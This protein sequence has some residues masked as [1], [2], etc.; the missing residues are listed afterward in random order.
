M[1]V[2]KN[3]FLTLALLAGLQLQAQQS[4]LIRNVR[5][6]DPSQNKTSKPSYILIKGNKIAEIGTNREPEADSTIE[7][8]GRFVLPGLMDGHVHYFQSGGLYTRPDAIDLRAI[9]PYEEQIEWVRAQ[10]PDFFQRYLAAG[11]TYTCD[12]GGPM[13]N[14]MLREEA[15]AE[16]APQLFVTGPLIST[17]QPE[18]LAV[19]DAPIVKVNNAAEARALVQ[20]QLPFKPDFIKIWYIVLP[21]QN[22]QDHFEIVK[23]TIEESHA[24]NIPVAVHATQFETAKLAVEAGC[25]ILVHSVEDEK[26]DQA[27]AQGL[28]KNKVSY[29][30]TLEVGHNYMEVFSKHLNITAEDYALANPFTLGSLMDLAHLSEEEVPAWIKRVQTAEA[31]QDKDQAVMQHNLKL[32]MD[33]G[34]NVVTGTDAGNIGTLHASSYFAEL[35]AMQAAGLSNAQILQASTLNGAKMLGQAKTMGQLKAGFAADLILLDGNP[36]D[37]LAQL[38]AL[39]VVVRKGVA[40]DA[41]A[42]VPNSPEI[43]AQRQLNAYNQRN[44]EAFVDCYA[45]SV[46][47]YGYPD[48]LYYTGKDKMGPNYGPMFENTPELHCELVN[49][50]VLGNTVIDHENVTG[51]SNGRIIKAVAI[52]TVENGKIS[53]VRFVQ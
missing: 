53:V 24:N 20:K 18:E 35:Q 36:L 2:I 27:F 6:V 44:I 22:A 13:S 33:A 4:L 25:D 17:Y 30:P 49:R 21:G 48:Q 32:L 15:K 23:A 43:M 5:L 51:F 9:K 46:Q 8:N 14:Y 52:Y 10:A 45:D 28:V 39:S 29:I 3:L 19:K 50:I 42:L 7:G 26:V 34:V 16:V 37:D 38:R 41:E 1:I 40:Y 47:I 11:I 12:V 31:P